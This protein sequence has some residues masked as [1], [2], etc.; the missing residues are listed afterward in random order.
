MGIFAAIARSRVRESLLELRLL[1]VDAAKAIGVRLR[2]RRDID[3]QNI[4]I[5]VELVGDFLQKSGGVFAVEW[6]PDQRDVGVRR[7][8]VDRDRALIEPE[9]SCQ[10]NGQ[11]ACAPSSGESGSGAAVIVVARIGAAAR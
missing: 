6:V 11:I 4:W 1:H 10:A 7:V 8:R 9:S 3:E 2:A 5:A